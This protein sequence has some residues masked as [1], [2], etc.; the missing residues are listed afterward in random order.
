MDSGEVVFLVFILA[1]AS[2]SVFGIS[3]DTFLELPSSLRGF[4]KGVI[5][6]SNILSLVTFAINIHHAS[7]FPSSL[8]R[9]VEGIEAPNPDIAG[10][11]I[12]WALWAQ[13]I[14]VFVAIVLGLMH[15]KRSSAKELG[16]ALLT[17]KRCLNSPLALLLDRFPSHVETLLCLLS[18]QWLE[19]GTRTHVEE[20]FILCPRLK[21]FVRL[22]VHDSTLPAYH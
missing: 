4:Q 13:T 14:N 21:I 19:V 8:S 1:Q 7:S 9:H 11:G 10:K 5:R 20:F 22:K 16:I 18:Y 15:S 6:I 17:G 2:C 12:R 3:S